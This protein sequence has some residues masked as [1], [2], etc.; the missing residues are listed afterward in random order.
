MSLD[1][2]TSPGKKRIT[3]NNS[4][5]VSVIS[6][7]DPVAYICADFCFPRELLSLVAL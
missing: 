2:R 1:F 3:R 5:K 6:E 4:S 7:F